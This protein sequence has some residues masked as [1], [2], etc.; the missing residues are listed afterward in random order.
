MIRK[1]SCGFGFCLMLS[2]FG[3]LWSYGFNKYG[4]LGQGNFVSN[5]EN[6]EPKQICKFTGNSDH[7]VVDICATSKGS[8]FAIDNKGKLYRW[9]LNQVDETHF[10][11]RDRFMTVTNYSTVDIL[12]KICTPIS[13]S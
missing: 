6:L 2:S 5:C 13:V 3:E 11:I 12:Y 10:P 7:F 9:G 8:S 1:I 4:Q